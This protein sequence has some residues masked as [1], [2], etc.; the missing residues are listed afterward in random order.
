MSK[1]DRRL[2]MFPLPLAALLVFATCGSN[3]STPKDAAVTPGDSSL[4]ADGVSCA[5]LPCLGHVTGLIASC[6]P[7]GACMAQAIVS[8]VAHCFANG[9]KVS[10][11]G[12]TLASGGSI[13]VMTVQKDGATCYS[14]TAIAESTSVGSAIYKDGAGADLVTKTVSGTTITVTCPGVSAVVA[15]SS[16]DAALSALVGI[17]PATSAACTAGTCTF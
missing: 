4:G 13:T 11:T 6:A 15:D 17:Y 2:A 14:Y 7:S 1:P 9:V 8:G 12:S 3:S 10:L 16:C 5:A